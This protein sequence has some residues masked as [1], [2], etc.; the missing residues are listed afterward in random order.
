M[1]W[2]TETKQ[3]IHQ[4]QQHDFH[5]YADNDDDENNAILEL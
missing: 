1:R 2:S 5:N 4:H 3:K